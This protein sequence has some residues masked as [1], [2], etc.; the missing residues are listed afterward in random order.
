[1]T[2][3]RLMRW[4]SVKMLEENQ[5][6]IKWVCVLHNLNN[7][8]NNDDDDD[9]DDDDNGNN[10]KVIIITITRIAP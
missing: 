4:C 3:T 9:D 6:K 7:N 10:S 2:T 1:M 8:N 5:L